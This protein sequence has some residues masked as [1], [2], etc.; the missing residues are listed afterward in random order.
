MRR[1]LFSILALLC[2]TVSSAWADDIASGNCGSTGHESDVTWK[3]SDAGVLTI[4]GTGAMKDYGW[5]G[6]PWNDYKDNDIKSV[7]IEEGVTNIP[8]LAFWDTRYLTSVSIPASVMTINSRAF[9]YCGEQSGANLVVT[10]ADGSHLASIGGSAFNSSKLASISIPASV[11]NIGN[12]AFCNCNNLTEIIVADGNTVYSSDGGVLFNKAKT[13]IIQYPAGKTGT[14]YDI[15]AGVTS[16]GDLAFSYCTAL[17]SVNIPASVTTIGN[18][19]FCNCNNLTEIT[20]ADGNTVYSSDGG[21]LFNKAKTTLI[22]YPAGNTGTSYTIPDGV[23]TIGPEAF[24]KCSNLESVTIGDDVESIGQSAF[25]WCIKLATVNFGS[26]VKTIGNNSFSAC[27][28][29]SVNIPASVT[30]IGEMA[31]LDNDNL[32]SVTIGSNVESIG[33]GAFANCTNLATVSLNSNPFIDEDAFNGITPAVTMNLTANAAGGAKWMTF[34]NKFYSFEADANTQVFKAE[35]SGKTIT[36]HE[37]DDKI[38][39]AGTAV[40]LKSTGNP[41]MTLTT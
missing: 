28:L 16:I 5:D 21:V 35:L 3:L 30:S 33:W 25:L 2:L 15:P 29:T 4:S 9:D 8:T 32:T 19:A 38:V 20:V 10:I 22:Q 36:L 23:T 31:F 17:T 14:S 34:Y 24:A 11:T 6:Y 26:K 13:T 41:V 1:K 12:E 39:N 18:E 37:V 27:A 40:V 7:V